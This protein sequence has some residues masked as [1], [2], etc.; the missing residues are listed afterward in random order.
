[1]T[2]TYD[3]RTIALLSEIIHPPIDLEAKTVQ[4]IHNELYNHE[5]AYQNFAVSH[6]GIALSNIGEQPNQISQVNFL[7][8]RI[9]IREEMTGSHVDDFT[10]RIQHVVTIAAER[11]QLPIIVAQQHVVRSLI[12]PRHF[13]DSREF[14]ANAVCG[15][16]PEDLN[17]FER[18]AQLF[19]MKM[20]FPNVEGRPDVH[21]L[22]IESFNQDAR[23]VFIE[24]VATFTTALMPDQLDKLGENMKLTYSFVR[25]KALSF[26]ARY[27]QASPSA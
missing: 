18:P 12:T 2:A 24:D 19:G 1:M 26:I 9:Q 14:L 20:I 13:S 17:P 21:T 3:P 25:D 27:D 22:R 23:C 16:Q 7:P 10:R 8:D 5:F 11:I 15:L 6:E 4:A